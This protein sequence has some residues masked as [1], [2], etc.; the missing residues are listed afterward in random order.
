[1]LNAKGVFMFTKLLF[2]QC[3]RNKSHAKKVAY[4]GLLTA[5]NVVSNVLSF[6]TPIAQFSLTIVVSVVTGIIAGGI[7]GF[8]VCVVADLIGYMI[9]S[10]GY[11]YMPWV[12]LSTGALALI[13]AYVFKNGFDKIYI[14]TLIVC[15]LS[16]VVCSVLINSTGLYFYYKLTNF[17]GGI[18]RYLNEYFNGRF[19]YFTFLIC[20]LI[21]AGQLI[22]NLLNYAVLFAV[23]PILKRLIK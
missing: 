18:V 6:P 22:N 8:A 1:M 13:S 11:F 17:D 5:F 15:L 4:L 3:L 21:F 23:I 20:R 7:S 14:K 12:A 2:S 19:T 10:F 16:L 9:N